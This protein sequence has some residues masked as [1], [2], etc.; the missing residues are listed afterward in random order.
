MRSKRLWAALALVAVLGITTAASATTRGL[1]TGKQIAPHSINSKKLVDHT[2]QKH[3]LSSTL[4]RSLR[5][6]KGPAGPQGATGAQGPTGVVDTKMFA[7][8]LPSVIPGETVEPSFG[9]MVGPTVIVTTTAT[10]TLVG[11]AV[12]VLGSMQGTYFG[13]GLCYQASGAT[14]PTAFAEWKGVFADSTPNRLPYAAAATVTPGAGTWEVGY[15]VNNLGSHFL[16][17]EPANPLDNNGYVN[18]WVQV[19]N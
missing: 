9:E 7:G 18:G 8:A 5:G 11:S 2:I 3:D 12:G 19:V 16:D 10:Q 17:G 6:A 15:C 13:F 1:I 14:E 4:V